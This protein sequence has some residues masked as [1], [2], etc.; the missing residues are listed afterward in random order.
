MAVQ[1]LPEGVDA[2][3]VREMISQSRDNYHAIED[4]WDKLVEMHEGQWV[5]SHEGQFVF[6]ATIEEVLAEATKQGWP[7]SV[8]A[9]DQLLRERANVLL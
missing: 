8:I 4:Q 6:G 7:L 2:E 9:I 1:K 5:A 3:A